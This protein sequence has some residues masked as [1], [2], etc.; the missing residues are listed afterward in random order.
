MAAPD[1]IDLLAPLSGDTDYLRGTAKPRV[2]IALTR[3]SPDVS[4]SRFGNH[5]FVP[6]DVRWPS[7]A[8]N[9]YRSRPMRDTPQPTR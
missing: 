6:R 5:P 7:H 8:A 4:G 2:D 9:A 3:E 1:P